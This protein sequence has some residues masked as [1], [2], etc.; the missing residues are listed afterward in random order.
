MVKRLFLLR[1]AKS[2]WAT[3]GQADHERPLNGKGREACALL[4]AHFAAAS[5]RPARVLC[6]TA[7]RT[8][9]TLQRIA[10][11]LGWKPLADYREGLYL[12]SAAN[13]L[14]AIQGAGTTESLLLIGH[15][16]GIEDL[17]ADLGG[18]GD[19]GA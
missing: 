3:P 16:P 2:S 14:K 17:A 13:L 12:A 8:R 5:I 7:T 9:E 4:A 1:H 10:A 19:A 15:N 11:E 18:D 6:S